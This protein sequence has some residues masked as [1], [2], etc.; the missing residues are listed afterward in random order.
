MTAELITSW[1]GRPSDT[2]PTS[3][4]VDYGLVR[5]LRAR[6]AERLAD[7]VTRRAAGSGGGLSWADQRVLGRS[8]VVDEVAG[9]VTA[10]ASTGAAAISVASEDALTDAVFSAIFRLGRLQPLLDDPLVENVDVD[11]CDQVWVSYADGR[12]EQASPVADTDTELIEVIQ[13]FAAWLGH[14][15]REFSTARPLLNLRLPDG[16][17]LTAW[18]GVSARP[19]LT[20]R[21]H[22]LSEVTLTDLRRIG[23]VTPAVAGFLAAAVRARKNIV[24]TGGLNAGKTTLLRALAAEFDPTEKIVV[25]EKEAE[26]GLDRLSD[27]H[28][29]VV[30]L[31]S[32]EANAE[33]AGEVSL[34]TL[35]VHALRMNARRI[36]VGEVRGDELL[37]ML[38][39]MSTGN[40]GSLC[41][42]HAN[43]SAAA[44]NRMVAIGLVAPQPVSP[45]GV[46]ALMADAVDFVVHLSLLDDDTDTHSDS[47]GRRAGRRVVSSIREIL[48]VGE[49]GRVTSNEVFRPGRDQIAMPVLA[50][51]CLP[52]LIACG[53]DPSL[54]QLD[55]IELGLQGSRR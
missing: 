37:P 7:E 3:A 40:P 18:M 41:T 12:I 54:L 36:L 43:S 15:A 11:G 24:I 34:A 6:V 53:F 21:R 4:R 29:R 14:S 47:N 10:Q 25:I 30:T 38:T 42:L 17:R 39:A 20:V 45:D 55:P 28:R 32:R 46:H 23:T 52:E 8:L 9:W 26:L 49:K 13:N 2:N 31:E 33:G 51:R 19:G 50:P 35:V 16:S 1:P 22:R 48:D 27:R 44:A 5:R